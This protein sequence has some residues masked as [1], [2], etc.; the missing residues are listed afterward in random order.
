MLINFF[1]QHFSIVWKNDPLLPLHFFSLD[2]DISGINCAAAERGIF[3][4]HLRLK[5]LYAAHQIYGLSLETL[6]PKEW[7]PSAFPD[8]SLTAQVIATA[9]A[10][11]PTTLS[12]NML[13][14]SF[15]VA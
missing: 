7:T 11:V 6:L 8:N 3:L 13:Q 10:T 9:C 12:I 2:C 5:Q 1:Q 15:A 14:N 4:V